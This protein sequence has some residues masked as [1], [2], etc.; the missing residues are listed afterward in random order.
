M[1][2]FDK[3]KIDR[4]IFCEFPKTEEFSGKQIKLKKIF[5][6]IGEGIIDLN[7]VKKVI[8][9]EEYAKSEWDEYVDNEFVRTR[10]P[11]AFNNREE[12]IKAIVKAPIVEENKWERLDPYSGDVHLI[13]E[14]KL[15]VVKSRIWMYKKDLWIDK[16]SGV[17]ICK[18]FAEFEEYFQKLVDGVINDKVPP[19][20]VGIHEDRVNGET[21]HILAGNSRAMIY[22]AFGLP[23]KIK[24]ILLKGRMLDINPYTGWFYKK[25]LENI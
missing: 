3:E 4:E 11:D 6:K 17:D 24:K 14:E 15:D 16:V 19:I 23:A 7:A 2:K 5:T 22:R 9:M 18:A 1:D 25:D 20:I 13:E 10:F 21:W 8:N 12:W